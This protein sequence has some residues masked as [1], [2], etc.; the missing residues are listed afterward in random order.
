MLQY[1]TQGIHSN[2]IPF[3]VNIH[4]Y[5][6]RLIIVTDD[7]ESSCEEVIEC[8]SPDSPPTTDPAPM[9]GLSDDQNRNEKEDDQVE[10]H[11]EE[12]AVD[13]DL[14]NFDSKHVENVSYS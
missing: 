8:I 13:V 7:D 3:I 10:I 12:V 11:N 1:C 2:N 5:L 9:I 14:S 4:Q 6:Y